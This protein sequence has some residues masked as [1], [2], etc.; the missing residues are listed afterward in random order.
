MYRGFGSRRELTE[1]MLNKVE[2]NCATATFLE[3]LSRVVF[4]S[5]S[6][7]C[8]RAGSAPPATGLQHVERVSTQEPLRT[9]DR[10]TGGSDGGQEKTRGANPGPHILR[11]GGEAA[12]TGS[13]LHLC[14]FL[15]AAHSNT[16]TKTQ[17]KGVL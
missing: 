10:V 12:V 1:K 7:C 14:V 13:A 11:L 6:C 16:S 17:R 3:A 15:V 5:V 9:P 4:Q 8:S 2:T